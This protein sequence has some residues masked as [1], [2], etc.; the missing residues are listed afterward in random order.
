MELYPDR[1]W[2]NLWQVMRTDLITAI[3]EIFG[4]PHNFPEFPEKVGNS[5]KTFGRAF[6]ALGQT[7]PQIVLLKLC[8]WELTPPVPMDNNLR[9][10]ETVVY[11]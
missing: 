4:I 6:G 5:Q 11:L 10:T 8:I 2:R 7:S 3:S 1:L 9:I